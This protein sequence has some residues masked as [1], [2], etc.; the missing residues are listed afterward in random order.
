[1]LRAKWKIFRKFFYTL[2][3][4]KYYIHIVYYIYTHLCKKSDAGRQAAC[5]LCLVCYVQFA[6]LLP[7]ILLL[8]AK[9]NK[10]T[11][12]ARMGEKKTKHNK[13]ARIKTT[14]RKQKKKR[15]IKEMK[16]NIFWQTIQG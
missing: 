8:P 3:C 10:A 5:V 4:E 15:S 13:Q 16:M 6:L 12:N 11:Q 7:A 14:K 2:L 9:Q 1:M